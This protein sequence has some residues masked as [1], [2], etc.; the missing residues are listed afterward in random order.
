[1]HQ[2]QELQGTELHLEGEGDETVVMVHGWPDTWRLWDAQVQALQGSRRCV[3]FTLPGFDLGRARRL[4]G[5]DEMVAFLLA[6]ADTASPHRPVTLLLHDWGCLFGYEFAMRHPHRVAR[7]VGLDVGDVA[8][9]AYLRS[10]SLGQ[11]AMIA[12]YQNW[13]AAAWK[14]GGARGDRMTRWMARQLRCPAAPAEIGAQMNYPYHLQWSGG[15]RGLTRF[16]PRWPMLFVYGR[17]KPFM[18]HSPEFVAQVEAT[19]GGRCYAWDAGHWLMQR[20]PEAFNDMLVG[21]LDATP[22]A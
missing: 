2:R 22:A 5:L 6:V 19:P 4:V 15:L 3:R 11:K 18:F 10:L 8:S 17:K 16:A 21:W 13:L 20:E 12:G 14:I 7:I 9:P 1:M